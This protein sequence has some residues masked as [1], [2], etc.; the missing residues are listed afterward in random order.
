MEVGCVSSAED[1]FLS[2]VPIG[3]VVLHRKDLGQALDEATEEVNDES[4]ESGSTDT[5]EEASSEEGEGAGDTDTEDQW[6]SLKDL[7]GE[8][9]KLSIKE[10]TIVIKALLLHLKSVHEQSIVVR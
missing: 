2:T 8:V 4:T 1:T 3:S 9:D 6:V 5:E 7:L 10:V